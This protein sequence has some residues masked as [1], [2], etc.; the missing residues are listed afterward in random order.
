MPVSG[1]VGSHVVAEETGVAYRIPRA[2]APDRLRHLE[3]LAWL[4]DRAIPIGRFRFGLDP[5]LGLKAHCGR[6]PPPGAYPGL[7]PYIP[8]FSPGET[9]L[10]AVGMLECKT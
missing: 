8:P 7:R 6:L 1:K 3:R 10:T 5:I 9:R 2:A 4:L